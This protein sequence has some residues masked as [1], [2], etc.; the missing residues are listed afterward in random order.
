[1]GNFLKKGWCSSCI[2]EWLGDCGLLVVD[3]IV[4][5]CSFVQQFRI[6]RL[7]NLVQFFINGV[8]QCYCSFWCVCQVEFSWYQFVVGYLVIDL[9]L[10]ELDVIFL[11]ILCNVL[12]LLV[13]VIVQCNL[14]S[15]EWVLLCMMRLFLCY[16]ILVD[17]V[18]DFLFIQLGCMV[19]L[20]NLEG[21]LFFVCGDFNQCLMC[22]GSC[23]FVDMCW[24]CL[25]LCDEMIWIF[26]WQIMQLNELVKSIVVF[27]VG[28]LGIVFLFEGMNNDGVI[29]VLVEGLMDFVVVVMWLVV[30][31]CEI[32][33]FVVKLFMIVV[34]VIDEQVVELFVE[35]LSEWLFDI[36]IKVVVFKDG[37]FMGNENDVCVFDIQYIKGL[38]FEVVFFI[39]VD[40]FVLV[41]FSLFDKYLYVGIMCVVIYLGMS[42]DMVLLFVM[43]L[44]WLQFLDC[45]QCV[46]ERKVLD[47]FF[48]F[49]VGCWVDGYWLS[50]GDF[51]LFW[52]Y[53][54]LKVGLCG[55]WF[56]VICGVCLVL[57]LKFMLCWLKRFMKFREL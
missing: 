2:V 40:R 52:C 38:E 20:V 19:V 32:E 46:D 6:C 4:V 22:W 3:L 25:D 50:L 9:D 49:E 36:N 37:K 48:F 16:Q 42:C 11:V 47:G 45:W 28:D 17:E 14:D 51:W 34:F 10:L 7:F 30:C 57:R 35:V 15:W 27:D 54:M 55:F 56:F 24:V 18:M 12:N 33:V 1:M 5:G 41:Q 53:F 8:L 29:L 44:L 21:F 43:V 26:Y 31:I 13:W 23:N 39:G